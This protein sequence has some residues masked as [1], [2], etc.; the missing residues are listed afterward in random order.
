MCSGSK[1]L[2]FAILL[3]SCALCASCQR[4]ARGLRNS[5]TMRA[6]ATPSVSS[7]LQPGGTPPVAQG[8]VTTA[9]EYDPFEGNA[10]AI[11]EGAQLYTMYNCKGCHMGG[12]GDM[13]PSLISQ[14]A[15]YGFSP[16]AMYQTIAFGRPNGMPAW[17]ARIPKYQI[18]QLIAYVRSMRGL[19]PTA[20]TPIR[21]DSMQKTLEETQ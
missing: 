14:K 12:G 9:S 17:G 3:Y 2:A 1:W 19:E 15:R 13:G 16:N 18:W 11:S 10:Y 6:F 7:Q 20:A 4:E 5:P 21:N 8:G